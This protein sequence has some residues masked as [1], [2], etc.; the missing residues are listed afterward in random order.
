MGKLCYSLSLP[1]TCFAQLSFVL[2][3]QLWLNLQVVEVYDPVFSELD[4]KTLQ[5]LGV[6]TLEQNEHAA[7]ALSEPTL[8]YMP[9]CEVNS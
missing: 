9:H 7:R 8:V 1:V 2:E 6:F 3:V 5:H 4:K